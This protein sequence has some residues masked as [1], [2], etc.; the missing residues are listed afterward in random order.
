MVY[1]VALAGIVAITMFGLGGISARLGGNTQPPASVQSTQNS[2]QPAA[3]QPNSLSVAPQTEQRQVIPNITLPD[4]STNPGNVLDGGLL[5]TP[6]P[7][8]VP[9]LPPLPT[10]AP[11]P[12]APV[13]SGNLPDTAQITP[14]LFTPVEAQG[15]TITGEASTPFYVVQP[16]DTLSEIAQRLG[17]DVDGLDSVNNLVDDT[18]YPGQVLYLPLGG[19]GLAQPP[20]EAQQP[21]QPAETQGGQGGGTTTGSV[22][23]QPTP[24]GAVVPQVPDMPN[25]GINKKR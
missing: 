19:G 5:P 23:A 16:G 1:L 12:T 25:T 6:T 10:L 7:T 21:Q 24:A 11:Q 13:P 15:G 20:A 3:I 17:V 14:Q 18:I 9:P 22:G 8:P 4:S 2:Q